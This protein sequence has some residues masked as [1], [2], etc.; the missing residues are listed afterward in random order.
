MISLLL[1]VVFDGETHFA[2][3]GEVCSEAFGGKRAIA[4]SDI[5]VIHIAR[6]NTRRFSHINRLADKTERGSTGRVSLQCAF[7]GLYKELKRFP[8]CFEGDSFLN[9]PV[10]DS[11]DLDP[12]T[13]VVSVLGNK[14]AAS[15]SLD[16]PEVNRKLC[17]P[18]YSLRI[19]VIVVD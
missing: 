17:S 16:S 14:E 2:K 8:V 19:V 11:N 5:H 7:E 4:P 12:A 18:S 10:E 1:F 13:A 15:E 9:L 6:A 3:C